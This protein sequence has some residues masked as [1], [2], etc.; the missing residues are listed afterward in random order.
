MLMAD[1]D[2]A[3]REIDQIQKIFLAT[4][5]KEPVT[6]EKINGV[7]MLNGKYKASLNPIKNLL[8]TIRDVRMQSI[9]SKGHVKNIMD[10]IAIYGIKVEIYRSNNEILKTFYVGGGTQNEY[11]TYFFMEHGSQPYIM[12]IPHFSGNIRSR[13]DLDITDWRDHSVFNI[14]TSAIEKVLVEYP[15]QPENSFI[16]KKE[17]NQF[18]LYDFANP[19]LKLQIAEPAMLKTYLTFFD[20]ISAEDIQNT[21][22]IRKV[23]AKLNP[24]CNIGIYQI[25]ST[26]PMTYK[27]FPMQV[28]TTGKVH[29]E[30]SQSLIEQGELFRWHLDRSDG[31]FLLLQYPNVQALLKKKKEFK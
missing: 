8:E 19:N 5:D 14:P 22:P 10:G 20:G 1:R 25:G 29:Y 4:R 23:A 17:E 15:Y 6:L 28:D 27:L 13:F 11:G 3:V 2:F 26:E 30:F 21:N 9:P 12:E 7:W 18:G 16:I 24:Y 31:D